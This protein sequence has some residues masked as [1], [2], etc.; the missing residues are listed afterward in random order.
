MID[1]LKNL[2]EEEKKI[3]RKILKNIKFSESFFSLPGTFNHKYL[4]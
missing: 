1:R 2:H 3:K 4:V